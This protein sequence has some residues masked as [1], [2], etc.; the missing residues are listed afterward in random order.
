MQC[1][2][3]F[4][5]KDPTS[6]KLPAPQVAEI[7]GNHIGKESAEERRFGLC[8]LMVA[9]LIYSIVFSHVIDNAAINMPDNVCHS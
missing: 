1:A 6:V 8:Y 3:T 4:A 5:G 2:A 7:A 9:G